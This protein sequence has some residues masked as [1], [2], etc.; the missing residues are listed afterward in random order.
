MTDKLYYRYMPLDQYAITNLY[1][2]T[3]HF[4]KA[5]NFDDPTD[6]AFSIGAIQP[7]LVMNC[8]MTALYEFC[9]EQPK[10]RTDPE[11]DPFIHHRLL[12]NIL[13]NDVGIACFT[14]HQMCKKCGL[15]TLNPIMLSLYADKHRGIIV[16]YSASKTTKIYKV[17]YGHTYKEFCFGEIIDSIK[18]RNKSRKVI[19]NKKS[20][21]PLLF[22]FNEWK[23]QN[24]YRMF[25]KPNF[26]VPLDK[27]GLSIKR[28]FIGCRAETGLV[29]SLERIA[30]ENKIEIFILKEPIEHNDKR[31]V[32]ILN[33]KGKELNCKKKCQ[34]NEDHS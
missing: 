34:L 27:L 16:E 20:S 21:K 32:R 18:L 31:R 26:S 4:N 12:E 29:A 33:K 13:K 2:N 11:F 1:D 25:G 28:I 23:Y 3:L 9:D 6:C 7:S 19:L 24:E 17:N 8:N 22:K 30:K 14:K 5:E 15:P 10:H